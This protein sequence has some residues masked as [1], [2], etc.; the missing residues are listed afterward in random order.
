LKTRYT[1]SCT[2][3]FLKVFKRIIILI[4][5]YQNT[6]CAVIEVLWRVVNCHDR[7]WDQ[8]GHSERDLELLHSSLQDMMTAFKRL[9]RNHCKSQ[10]RFLKFHLNLHLVS[11]IRM[12]GSLR[13]IDTGAGERENKGVKAMWLRTSRKRYDMLRQMANLLARRSVIEEVARERGLRGGALPARYH[14]PPTDIM[15]GLAYK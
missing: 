8:T 10:C 7:L 15:R 2:C 4:Y 13:V 14:A 11:T 3:F 5:F 9:F 1:T 6:H 12:W